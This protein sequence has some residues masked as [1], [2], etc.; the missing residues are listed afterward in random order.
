MPRSG[1]IIY[2]EDDIDDQELFTEAIEQ[3]KIPNKV[4]LIANGNEALH[5]LRTTSDQPFLIFCDINLPQLNGIELRDEI[6]QDAYL[7]DKCIPF[8]YLTTTANKSAVKEA[9]RMNVQG[10][11][12]KPQNFLELLDTVKDIV[13]YWH[14]CRHPNSA[15][16]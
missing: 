4:Q 13:E 14:K 9:Y 16:E 3:L 8:V 2:V 1:P 5:Y 7:S 15:E 11:F 6:N 10:F 12:V